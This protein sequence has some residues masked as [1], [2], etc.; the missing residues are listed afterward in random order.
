MQYWSARLAR[1]QMGGYRSCRKQGEFP[2]GA[3]S[4]AGAAALLNYSN[5]QIFCLRARQ[6]SGRKVRVGT[7]QP[8]LILQSLN[9]S[10]GAGGNPADTSVGFLEQ[11]GMSTGLQS[12][13]NLGTLFSDCQAGILGDSEMDLYE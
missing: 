10:S 4:R 5:S 9:R 12:T 13:S 7:S 11:V 3:I 2:K 1:K 8:E 6:N